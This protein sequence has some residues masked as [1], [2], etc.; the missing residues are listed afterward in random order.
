MVRKYGDSAEGTQERLKQIKTS[1]C[2][3]TPTGDS[4]EGTQE[5]FPKR[6]LFSTAEADGGSAEGTQE[7]LKLFT[8]VCLPNVR[9]VI[10]PKELKRD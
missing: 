9:P 3:A 8:V 1:P 7:R 2:Q 6:K 10:R 5:R 4:A